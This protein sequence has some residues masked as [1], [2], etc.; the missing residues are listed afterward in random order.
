MWSE[1]WATREPGQ[2]VWSRHPRLR[3]EARDSGLG[4]GGCRLWAE[5]HVEGLPGVPHPPALK[6]DFEA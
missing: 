1:S 6:A 2:A 3:A 4:P 5:P